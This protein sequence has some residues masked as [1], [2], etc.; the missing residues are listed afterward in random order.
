MEED[1]SFK[2]RHWIPFPP[3]LPSSI[4]AKNLFS[5]FVDRKPKGTE[6]MSFLKTNKI[7]SMLLRP[8]PISFNTMTFSKVCSCWKL[9]YQWTPT[10]WVR[11]KW[12]SD[13]SHP[14][15][16]DETWDARKP[17]SVVVYT[18][19]P[20]GGVGGSVRDMGADPG[21]RIVK[22]MVRHGL[23]VDAI[24][25]LYQRDGRDEWT[26]WWG[27]RGGQLSE[28]ILD[29]EGEECLAWISGRYGICGGYLV[30]R[31]LTF[32]SNK[33]T[34]GPYGMEDGAPFKLDAGGQSIVGFFA[35]AGQFLDAI[36]VY[37]A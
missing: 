17:S 26:D 34:Y 19:G 28:I 5:G 9:L 12:E 32:G 29:D 35:R 20:C 23:A 22:V 10:S 14:P 33:R 15:G 36:G 8:L 21:T 25:I 16:G 24:R 18:S 13:G 4:N 1:Q 30:I 3:V 7:V 31:S 37:T 27:G 2:I 11:K 6:L